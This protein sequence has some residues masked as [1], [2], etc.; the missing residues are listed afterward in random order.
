[1]NI[2]E[3]LYY[4]TNKLHQAKINTAELEARILLQHATSKSLEY[5]LARPEQEL[6]PQEQEAFEQLLTRRLSLEPIAYITNSK[7]FYGYDFIVNDKV[8]IPRSD[9]EL[10]IDVILQETDNDASIE[11]LELGTGSGCIAVSLLLEMP[12][13]RLTASDISDDAIM[14][15]RQNAMNHNVLER[16]K[17]INSDWFRTLEKQQFDI[18]VSNP[19]YIA[20]DDTP[21][22]APETLK[23]EPHLA[24]FA[25]DNGLAGY[26][27]IAKEARHFLKPNGKL[28]LEIGFNQA[29]D[30]T[31]IFNDSGYVIKR[32]Y[33]D[34]AGHDRVILIV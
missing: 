24:L 13:I 19:P 29:N 31:K 2:Q 9:T 27:S 1:M 26:H 4:A 15:A 30:V 5:L 3:N 33:K 8:L 25:E 23:H 34:L 16:A 22:I 17:I 32:V 11:V 6:I 28:F 12:N 7:E 18:I 21:N 10:L 14:V 20:L